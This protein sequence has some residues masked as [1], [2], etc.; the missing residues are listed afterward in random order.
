MAVVGAEALSIVRVPDVDD[1]VLA[2]GEQK[3]AF[4][5]VFDLCGSRGRERGAA[6]VAVRLWPWGA[7]QAGKRDGRVRDRSWPVRPVMAWS[8][9]QSNL[10]L[11]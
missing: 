10:K 8:A 4:G 7:V 3:V 6:S 5:I 11:M 1:V 2:R 9:S